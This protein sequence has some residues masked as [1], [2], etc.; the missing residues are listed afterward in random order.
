MVQA[1][2]NGHG[3]LAKGVTYLV[4]YFWICDPLLVGAVRFSASGG[5]H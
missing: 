4:Y 1:A 2:G 3:L 5:V